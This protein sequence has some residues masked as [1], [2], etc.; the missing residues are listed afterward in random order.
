MESLEELLTVDTDGNK[1]GDNKTLLKEIKQLIKK[2][3]KVASSFKT[4][5]QLP[6]EAV[7]VIGNRLVTIKFNLDEKE[8][9]VSNVEVDARDSSTMNHMAMSEAMDRLLAISGKHR[10]DN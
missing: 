10:G 6:Y 4:A 2:K 9:V 5:E 7:S 8:A 1:A 3:K